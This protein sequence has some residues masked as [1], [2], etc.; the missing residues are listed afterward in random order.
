MKIRREVIVQISGI[1]IPVVLHAVRFG[2][3]TIKVLSSDGASAM[4]MRRGGFL[5]R[6]GAPDGKDP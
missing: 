4:A 2:L 3:F 5:T 1:C 6:E